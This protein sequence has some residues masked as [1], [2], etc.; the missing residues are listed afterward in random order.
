[1][2]IRAIIMGLTFALIWSSAFT[3]ARI[4]VTNASP[5]AA[6]SL[7]FF[8]SGL[9]GISIARFL[10]QKWHLTPNQ[11]RA[12][13]IFG[14]CQNAI[15]LGLNFYAMQTVEASLASIIAS[16][17]PLLVAFAGWVFLKD[18]LPVMSILGLIFGMVGVVIIMSSRINSGIDFYGVTFCIIAAIALTVATLS[19]KSMSSGEN[20]LMVVGLQMLVGAVPLTIA[21]ALTE[22][23]HMNVTAGLVTA[24]I[25]TTLAPGLLATWIWFKLVARIGATRAATFHF[26]NPLIGVTIAA[27]VLGESLSKYDIIGVIVIM[28]GILAVQL[29]RQ[30]DR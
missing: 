21:S 18:S 4:I 17:M 19:I 30:V 9:I 20:L 16:S 12:T 28:V 27:I 2:D 10:G 22:T 29:S 24:F 15:Y 7:R 11:W 6:L 25:Y 13:I 14:V 8:I 5:L 23:L 26:L 1:M 3:S